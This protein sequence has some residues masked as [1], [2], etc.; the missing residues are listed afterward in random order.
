MAKAKTYSAQGQEKSTMELP[1]HL[2]AIKPHKM[3]L[4]SAVRRHMTN[5][6][7][8]TASTKGRSEV[9]GG[10]AKPWRQKGTGRA[11]AGTR[12]SP[13]WVGGGVVF[14][15]KPRKH[16]MKL[17]QKVISLALKSA[18]SSCAQ[19]GR[20]AVIESIALESPKTKDLYKILSNMGFATGKRL[21]IVESYEQNIFKSGRNIPGLTLRTAKA[22]HAYDILNSDQVILTKKAL[23]RMEEVF[24]G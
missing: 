16:K 1:A 13:L 9:R 6:R 18:L 2:F 24:S 8:G 15:P 17:P 7:R 14:G 22:I 12:R 11:R 20:V 23:E 21:L 19:D 10:G 5:L 3:A 4:Y